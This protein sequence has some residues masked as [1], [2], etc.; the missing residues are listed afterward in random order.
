MLMRGVGRSGSPPSGRL[1]VGLSGTGFV[2]RN[3][4][5]FLAR[6]SDFEVTGV[7]TRRPVAA[8]AAHFPPEILT[9]DLER[10][11]ERA[12]I[13][14]ECSGDAGHAAE[15]L[16]AAGRAGRRLVTMNSE[17][18]VTI[19][20]ALLREGFDLTE[21]HGDQPGCLAELDREAREFGFEPL[22]YVNLK[23]F[24][25][26]DPSRADM[27]YWGAKQGLSLGQVT[28]FTDGSK[29][30]IEQVLVANGLGARIARRGMIGG[31]A[32]DLADLDHLA[33]A[34]L[35]LGAPISDYVVHPGGPPGVLILAANPAADLAEGYMP[36]TRLKTR[37]GTAYRFLRP[38]HLIHL[39]IVKTLRAVAVGAPPLLTNGLHPTATAA[40]VAKRAMPAGTLIEKGLGG[41]DLRGEAV[42]VAEIPDAA[43]ITLMDG[44]RLRQAVEPGQVLTWGDVDLPQSLALD[45]YLSTLLPPD[46]TMPKTRAG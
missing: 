9:N 27:E 7:L 29:L 15:V 18:Q 2:A 23:G 44:A 33:E 11:I 30:Q 16:M 40:A 21:A 6:Q 43:P 25:N 22:A 10:L 45:L 8:S 5:A 37:N 12:D 24:L 13:V 42:E 14:L 31:R 32:E 39:E 34:A 28:S 41:F 4:H 46:S 35:A 38:H 26:P 20:S 36:F 17:A 19:G 3:L 1:R